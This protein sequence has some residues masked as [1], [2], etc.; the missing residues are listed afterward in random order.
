MLF[1]SAGSASP[2]WLEAAG[3]ISHKGQVYDG[4]HEAIIDKATWDLVEAQLASST[5]KNGSHAQAKQPSL[6]AGLLVDDQGSAFTCSHAVKNSKRYRYYI[7]APREER[8]QSKPLRLPAH[9][10][11]ADR[12]SVV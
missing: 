9:E 12:K 5:R 2:C 11:E 6:L 4:L 1:T 8:G 7:G 3:K 10:I